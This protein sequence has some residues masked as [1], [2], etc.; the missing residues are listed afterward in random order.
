MIPRH[1]LRWTLLMLC[2]LLLAVLLIACGGG[3]TSATST[4][5][6]TPMPTTPPSPT[7]PPLTTYTG[8]GYTIGYPQG[9]KVKTSS[10]G[11][12]FTDPNGLAYVT[13]RTAPNPNGVVTTDTQTSLAIQVFKSSAKNEQKVDIAAT[14]MVGGD[15]WSQQ[16]ATGDIT[17]SGQS[18]PVNVKI[19]VLADNHPANSS[20]TK[21]FVIGY[22]TGTPLF[23]LANTSVFQPILQSFKFTS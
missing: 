20:S 10:D 23:D 11:V 3:G 5:T 8:S 15:T 7:P 14:A 18:S 6:P 19:V 4:P 21:S 12:T 1:T 17:P 13:V 16:A 22:A 2:S 9:W